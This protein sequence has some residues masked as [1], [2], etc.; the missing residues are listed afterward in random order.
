MLFRRNDFMEGG[1]Q[2]PKCHRHIMENLGIC[3]ST[4]FFY[5]FINVRNVGEEY[6]LIYHRKALLLLFIAACTVL[7]L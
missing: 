5:K 1:G 7:R 4:F 6:P 3:M 2:V